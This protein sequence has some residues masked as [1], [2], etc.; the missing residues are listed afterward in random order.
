MSGVM[1]SISLSTQPWAFWCHQRE[2]ES[3]WKN[4]TT[5]VAAGRAQSRHNTTLGPSR[6]TYWLGVDLWQP[7]ERNPQADGQSSVPV[8]RSLHR[9]TH[10]HLFERVCQKTGCNFQIAFS[11][12]QEVGLVGQPTKPSWFKITLPSCHAWTGEVAGISGSSKTKWPWPLQR[13]YRA[14]L[15]G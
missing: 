9:R 13:S 11:S 2:R 10:W 7:R 8:Q 15:S 1:L 5:A 6:M 3:D 12:N 14:A 4:S